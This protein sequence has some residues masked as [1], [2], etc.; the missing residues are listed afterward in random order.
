[1]R[2]TKLTLPPCLSGDIVPESYAGPAQRRNR[3]AD[4]QDSFP[5]LPGI[6]TQRGDARLDGQTWH[7][8]LAGVNDS[9]T[10][11]LRD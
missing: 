1:M 2:P 4:R 8:A 6:G 3:H 10:S 9:A 7:T 5:P 11:I